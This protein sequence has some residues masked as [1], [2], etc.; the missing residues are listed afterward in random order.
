MAVVEVLLG[1]GAALGAVLAF[2]MSVIVPLFQEI[3]KLGIFST[4]AVIIDGQVKCVGN[5]PNRKEWKF[6]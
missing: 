4:P 3:A 5:D 2:M 6:G 1:K